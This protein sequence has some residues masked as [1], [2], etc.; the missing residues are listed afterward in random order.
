MRFVT[1]RAAAKHCPKQAG[2]PQQ[3]T[4]FLTLLVWTGICR[5]DVGKMLGHTQSI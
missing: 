4:C 3:I 5:G 1:L 2:P